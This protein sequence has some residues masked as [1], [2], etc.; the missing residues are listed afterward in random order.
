M[1]AITGPQIFTENTGGPG[2]IGRGAVLA[3]TLIYAGAMLGRTAAGYVR[4]FVAGDYFIGHALET[5]D[6]SSGSSGDKRVSYRRGEY[7]FTVPV[8]A[9]AT[10]ANV[11][12]VVYSTTNNHADLVLVDPGGGAADAVGW[13][14]DIKP[15]GDVVIRA[16]PR[17]N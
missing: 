5:V 15:N 7:Y 4:N 11:G 10:I 16:N 2:G 6:N 12:D 1:A 13:V 3:S 17:T 9:S 14:H 8:F